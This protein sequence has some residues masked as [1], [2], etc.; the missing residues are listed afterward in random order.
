MIDA[1]A[2]ILKRLHLNRQFDQL[3]SRDSQVVRSC[4]A[5]SEQHAI[6]FIGLYM[7]RVLA[8]CCGPFFLN[9]VETYDLI[10]MMSWMCHD[11]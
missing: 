8:C 1:N 4:C 11:S 2:V 6:E 5:P 7:L 10:V 9:I 3:Q